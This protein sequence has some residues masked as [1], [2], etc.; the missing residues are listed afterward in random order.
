M[1]LPEG[2]N[3][4][5]YQLPY[6]PG[7]WYTLQRWPNS[8]LARINTVTR[9]TMFDC[10]DDWGVY[11]ETLFPA[12]GNLFLVFLDTDWDDIARGFLRPYG[13]RAR[14]K[15]RD[16][17]KKKKKRRFSFE[18]PEIGEIIGKNLPGARAIKG[19]KVGAAWRWFW[20]I[21]G[22][23]QRALYYWML[24]DVLADFSYAWSTG[25][26][27]H[28]V[29]WQRDKG[30]IKGGPG[31]LSWSANGQW[32]TTGLPLPH[33]RGGDYPP[34]GF[35]VYVPPGDHVI[36][37]FELGRAYGFLRKLQSVSARMIEE[38]VQS[39][40]ARV[41]DSSI[42]VQVENLEDVSPLTIVN[43]ENKSGT[44]K[45]I[46]VQVRGEAS[47]GDTAISTDAWGAIRRVKFTVI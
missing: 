29:C 35:P 42:D 44:A 20:R 43:Y 13:I 33:Q 47:P 14:G 12:L 46:K 2:L 3:P 23:L 36:A 19:R 16:K 40:E 25:I 5:L 9:L 21:D 8:F 41:L 27:R 15:I 38:D 31:L 11:V 45:L 28:E 10:G 32:V 17:R 30:W 6:G 1:N 37:G 22:I 24:V 18:I 34:P 26:F 39:G 7:L 4:I